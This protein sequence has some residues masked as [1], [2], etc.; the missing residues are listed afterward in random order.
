ME[1]YR[2]ARANASTS[3]IICNGIVVV[4]KCDCGA[5]SCKWATRA[6]TIPAGACWNYSPVCRLHCCWIAIYKICVENLGRG[7]KVP[8]DGGGISGDFSWKKSTQIDFLLDLRGVLG[9]IDDS[10]CFI[11]AKRDP[12]SKCLSGPLG[13]FVGTSLVA[14]RGVGTAGLEQCGISGPPPCSPVFACTA[15]SIA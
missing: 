2:Q 1:T 7:W 12:R 15:G 13:T 4:C 14:D 8:V 5:C 9:S 6:A 10:A 3:C 11:L